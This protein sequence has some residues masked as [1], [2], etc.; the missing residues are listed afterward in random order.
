MPFMQT[1]LSGTEHVCHTSCRQISHHTQVVRFVDQNDEA[2]AALQAVLEV[3]QLSQ[4]LTFL[5]HPNNCAGAM[6]D[7]QQ[8]IEVCLPS[9]IILCHN[10]FPDMCMPEWA[11]KGLPVNLR[12]I[13]AC[14]LRGAWIS[15]VTNLLVVGSARHTP[16]R[17]LLRCHSAWIDDLQEAL[18]PFS[19]SSSSCRVQWFPSR[20]GFLTSSSD[21]S[22]KPCFRLLH[23]RLCTAS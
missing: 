7:M 22:D 2:I 18:T 14:T 3:Q 6:Q 23:C 21:R 12:I 5:G 15:R 11:S 8:L 4:R 20:S 9:A 19:W 17:E 10:W 1:S 13:Y 16:D